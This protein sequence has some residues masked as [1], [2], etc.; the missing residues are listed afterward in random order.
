MLKI[1]IGGKGRFDI[2]TGI[3]RLDRDYLTPSQ[4][5]TR[6]ALYGATP[7]GIKTL[8]GVLEGWGYPDEDWVTTGL[9]V[10]EPYPLSDIGLRTPQLWVAFRPSKRQAYEESREHITTTLA[11]GVKQIVHSEAAAQ[12]V[13]APE[14]FV[15]FDHLGDSSGFGYN[16]TGDITKHW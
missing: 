6:A 3:S 12:S 1:W 8:N 10:V 5:V 2:Y 13:P 11:E 14:L 7:L 4:K 16:R 9:T 15:E